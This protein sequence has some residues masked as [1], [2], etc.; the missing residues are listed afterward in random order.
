MRLWLIRHGETDHN[1]RGVFQGQLDTPLTDRG[2]E[3][4]AQTG[5]ALA[6][7]VR[8]DR[9]YASDLQRAM[10]TARAVGEAQGAEVRADP[11][12]RELH[13][14]VLQGVAYTDFRTVLEEHGLEADWGPG[15][16]SQ[17]GIAAPGGESLDDLV[18]RLD[19][20]IEHVSRN[21]GEAKDVAAVAH[22]G[23]LRTIMTILLGLPPLDRGK[24]AMSNCGVTQL[25]LVDG[26]WRLEFHNRVFWEC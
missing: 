10:Q 20:F 24:F 14:G 6:E 17:S 22:G 25:A 5:R 18:A 1:I 26:H 16:F 15:V 11:R 13:Y 2:V 8:F 21:D 23:S 9:I 7:I 3:Q 19:A 12:L 4:A